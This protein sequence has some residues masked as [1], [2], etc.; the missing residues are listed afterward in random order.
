[1]KKIAGL[2]LRALT[3]GGVSSRGLCANSGWPE[4]QMCSLLWRLRS[5][6]KR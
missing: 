5:G 4:R 2:A 1:M 6:S 3:P